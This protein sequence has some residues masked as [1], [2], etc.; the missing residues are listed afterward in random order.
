MQGQ[1]LEARLCQGPAPSPCSAARAA[2]GVGTD[3]LVHHMAPSP[4]HRHGPKEGISLI[5][6]LV[7]HGASSAI[8][9]SSCRVLK[10]TQSCLTLCGPVDSSME[11]S[12]PESW[13]G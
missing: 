8:S 5:Q 2:G 11:F 1:H 13:S 10:V 9:D 6:A 4:E 3:G 12:R 7:V